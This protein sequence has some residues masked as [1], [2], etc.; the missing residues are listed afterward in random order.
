MEQIQRTSPTHIPTHAEL[1]ERRKKALQEETFLHC[2]ILQLWQIY[3]Y[4]QKYE[5][6]ERAKMQLVS[7]ELGE[8]FF[9]LK[10]LLSKPGKNGQWSAWL[11]SQRINRASADRLSARYMESLNLHA[12]IV[13]EAGSNDAGSS[14]QRTRGEL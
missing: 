5:K 10:K 1:L 11:R 7:H 8:L 4:F 6:E 9:H 3:S 14:P 12:P 2:E 13:D